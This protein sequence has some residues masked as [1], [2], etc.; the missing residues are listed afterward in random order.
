MLGPS[1]F[2]RPV[3]G[4]FLLPVWVPH[5]QSAWCGVCTVPFSVPAEAL[6]AVESLAVSLVSR[7]CLCPQY[8]FQCGIFMLS[9]GEF[10]PACGS[11]SGL[12]TPIGGYLGVFMG[13]GDFNVLLST[14][15]PGSPL[16]TMA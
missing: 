2:Q 12:L 5:A 8:C 14:I 10:V 15:F 9:F 3:L 13:Q 16:A 4:G 6:P 1:G 7:L 11:S